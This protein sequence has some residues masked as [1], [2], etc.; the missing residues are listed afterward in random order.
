MFQQ[1]RIVGVLLFVYM[2]Q[3]QNALEVCAPATCRHCQQFLLFI[4]KQSFDASLCWLCFC[5]SVLPEEAGRLEGEEDQSERKREEK[6]RA[7]GPEGQ[8][9]LIPNKVCVQHVKQEVKRRRHFVSNSHAAGSQIR[10]TTKMLCSS[11]SPV[12]TSQETRPLR[13]RPWSLPKPPPSVQVKNQPMT[14]GACLL[15]SQ[16]F[17]RRGPLRGKAHQHLPSLG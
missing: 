17:K 16:S 7:R 5:V 9:P 4:F 13:K 1:S 6:Q 11:H 2:L 14:R 12:S 10:N 8:R 15:L 3:L